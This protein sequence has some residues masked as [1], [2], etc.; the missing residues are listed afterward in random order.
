MKM[1]A[2]RA[3]GRPT[4]DRAGIRDDGSVKDRRRRKTTA[5]G[6]LENDYLDT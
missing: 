2:T 5:K 6:Q 3:S 4:A 1:H